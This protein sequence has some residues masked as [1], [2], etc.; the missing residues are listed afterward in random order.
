MPAPPGEIPGLE[1][2][3]ASRLAGGLVAELSEPDRT[4]RATL[5]ERALADQP[6]TSERELIDYLADR[7]AASMLSVLD[8]LQRVTAAA[9]A[10]DRPL[11]AALAREVLEGQL[12]RDRR[13]KGMRTSGIVVSSASGVRS[14]EKMVWE[15]PDVADRLVGDLP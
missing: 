4:V 14:R 12:A 5:L 7:P 13:T 11:T 6:G 3:I 8:A 10:Q 15:W 9:A 1:P 2:R